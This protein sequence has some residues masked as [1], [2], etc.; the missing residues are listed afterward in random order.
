MTE[1]AFPQLAQGT[2]MAN[3]FPSVVNFTASFELLM[4]FCLSFLYL[5]KVTI[6][7]LQKVALSNS[8][9]GALKGIFFSS[10]AV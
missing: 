1:D 6:L 3:F 10:R 7:W 4:G 2:A 8:G 5:S 9:Q